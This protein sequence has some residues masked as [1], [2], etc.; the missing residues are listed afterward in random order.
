MA[1]TGCLKTIAFTMFGQYENQRFAT[2][3]VRRIDLLEGFIYML[4][5]NARGYLKFPWL[6]QHLNPA[7]IDGGYGM[8]LH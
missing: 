5:D 8:V 3:K 7:N 6:N 4:A 1:T 2:G